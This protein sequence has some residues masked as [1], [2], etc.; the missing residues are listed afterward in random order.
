MKCIVVSLSDAIHTYEAEVYA[1]TYCMRIELYELYI[2]KTST[3]IMAFYQYC[4][5]HV[6][7]SEGWWHLGYFAIHGIF[8][9][10][11]PVEFIKNAEWSI[12]IRSSSQSLENGEMS[13]LACCQDAIHRIIC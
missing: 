13:F 4:L 11:S 9:E 2:D 12:S 7:L 1:R 8:V 5:M 3:H 10:R 6:H